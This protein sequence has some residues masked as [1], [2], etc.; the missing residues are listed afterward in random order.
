MILLYKYDSILLF[1]GAGEWSRIPHCPFMRRAIEID[2]CFI[3]TS[4]NCVSSVD[5]EWIECKIRHTL[6]CCR[7]LI[8]HFRGGE[9]QT[10]TTTCSLSNDSAV[11]MEN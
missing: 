10:A 6:R 7:L 5:G 3:S 2:L 1:G 4:G 8:F 9:K 11:E